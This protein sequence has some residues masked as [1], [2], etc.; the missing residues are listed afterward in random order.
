LVAEAR[1]Y[2]QQY[3]AAPDRQLR[4]AFDGA[5][6]ER[7]LMQNGEPIWG[8][9]RPVTF[10][11]LALP[12]GPQSGTVV[13][14][15][16]ASDVKAA[17]EAEAAARGTPLLWPS[18]AELQSNRVDFTA[19]NGQAAAS[20]AEL[21]RRLG[22]EGVLVGRAAAAGAGA[23]IRG[24]FVFQ[25]HGSELSGPLEGVDG[26]ADR[27]AAL[28]SATGNPAPLDIEVEGVADLAAYAK[29]QHQLESVSIVS[30]VGLQSMSGDIAAFRL[31]A[32]GGAVSLQRALAL[33]G[34]LEPVTG[35]AGG[36]L[37][38]RLRP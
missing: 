30:H 12:T 4:V 37:R 8:P 28:F 15:E 16:D 34:I 25:D 19:V 20:L 32:R 35:V 24:V 33:N 18:A 36:P 9:E 31:I 22:G 11:W 13:S 29:L 26:A 27:Y 38:F 3:R 6:I 5:A 7:W 23:N 14:R 10:V 21:G 17:I 2:V 1:R